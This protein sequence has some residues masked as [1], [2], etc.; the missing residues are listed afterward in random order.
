MPVVVSLTVETDGHLPSGQP[1]LEAIDEVDA[2]T[3][4]ATLHFGI[5]CAHPDHF[6][7]VL[8]SAA[9]QVARIGLL[10]ANASRMSHAEL[11]DAEELDD[12]DPQ[13]LASQY[14]SLLADYPHL[15]VLG[16]CCG[17]DVRHV[18]A[19]GRACAPAGT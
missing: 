3:N 5:N 18:A 7:P 13:E 17:T 9:P 8:D 16:G 4:G 12:G 1:L 11:D 10:R 14:K 19:I 2:A 6:T 15:H